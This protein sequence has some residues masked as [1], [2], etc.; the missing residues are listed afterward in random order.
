[1]GQRHFLAHGQ[2]GIV[3]MMKQ[4]IEVPDDFL[5][6]GALFRSPVHHAHDET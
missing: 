6:R 4:R 1:M 2:D 3:G 5:V